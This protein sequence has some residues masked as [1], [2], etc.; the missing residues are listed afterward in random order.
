MSSTPTVYLVSGSNRGIGSGLVTLLAAR[1]NTVVF[2][3]CRNPAAATDL[4]ALVA[5]HPGKVHIVKIVSGDLEGNKAAVE[6]VRKIAGRLDVAIANAAIGNYLGPALQ[7]PPEAMREHFE[8][9]VIGTLVFFQAV[10]PLLK[11][12]TETPK[13]IPIASGAGSMTDGARFPVPVLAY[14][15][16][17]AA[18]N[19]LARKLWFECPGLIC[20]PIEP[21]GTKTGLTETVIQAVPQMANYP[22]QSAEEAAANLLKRIDEAERGGDDGPGYWLLPYAGAEDDVLLDIPPLVSSVLGILPV[23]TETA[24]IIT[25]T[26]TTTVT[27][28]TTVTEACSPSIT[29]SSPPMIWRQSLTMTDLDEWNITNFACGKQNLNIVSSIPLPL[30]ASAPIATELVSLTNDIPIIIARGPGPL[31]PTESP[32]LLRITYPIHSSDPS[33]TPLGGAD[34]YSNP[35]SIALKNATSVSLSYSVFFP[36]EFDFVRGGKLPG[37]YGGAYGCSGGKSAEECWSSRLMWRREG[38]GE[39]YLY[40]PKAA[41]T[42]ALCSTPPLTICGSADGQSIG[43]GSFNFTRG[44]W[45]HVLQRVT[46]N[47]PGEWDGEF[48]LWANGKRVIKL[49]GMYWRKAA[50]PSTPDEGHED[51]TGGAGDESEENSPLLD[52]LQGILIETSSLSLGYSG[53][54]L[55]PALVP[56]MN[57]TTLSQTALRPNANGVAG[58]GTHRPPERGTNTSLKPKTSKTTKGATSPHGPPGFSGIFFSTFFGGSGPEWATPEETWTW[59]K[60]FELVV[61]Y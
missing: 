60:D 43:R 20:V 29:S 10:Y 32:S 58:A 33:L 44:A 26:V 11:A 17:K 50:T 2:C 49:D 22:F 56:S 3:G 57:N 39:L 61:H 28:T 37:L 35:L 24:P 19:Y 59:F 36:L 38:A 34:F 21:G 23:P 31:P 27:A 25:I 1:E 16:S 14:G 7:T 40:A 18:E 46:L 30:Y 13:F 52:Q 9:N 15:A 5:K 51:E 48:E 8:V 55:K 42:S 4:D 53:F 54:L 41:Q 45:T 12:S 6:E 47:T